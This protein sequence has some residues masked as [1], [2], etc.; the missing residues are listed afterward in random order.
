[1]YIISTNNMLQKA[2]QQGYA[3]PAFNIH[4]L[5][6]MQVV[7]ETAAHMH[8]PVILAGRHLSLCGNG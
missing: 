7:A 3:V 8:S 2:Q 5:E 6:T 1:M 4:N